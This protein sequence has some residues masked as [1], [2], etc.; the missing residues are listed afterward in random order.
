MAPGSQHEAS[1][2]VPL[3][4][5]VLVLYAGDELLDPGEVPSGAGSQEQLARALLTSHP[6]AIFA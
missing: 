1:V 4:H 2:V 5:H 3:L 6:A